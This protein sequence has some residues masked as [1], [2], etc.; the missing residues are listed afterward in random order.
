MELATKAFGQVEINP[1]NIT[2]FPSGLY[3]FDDSTE[4]VIIE[5]KEQAPFYW[6]QS[7]KNKDLAFVLIRPEVFLKYP[8]V[9]DISASDME[10]LSIRN[11]SECSIYVIVTIPEK[12]PEK[13][14]ANLQGPILINEEKKIGRQVIS[15][16]DMHSVRVLILEQLEG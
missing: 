12:E 3:G 11:I 16:N 5:D 6:M 9:P 1:V 7:V 10:L 4:F 8:Y 15:N 2:K 13:M 14:T